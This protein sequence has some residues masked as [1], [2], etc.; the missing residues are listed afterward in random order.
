M[1]LSTVKIILSYMMVI[2]VKSDLHN[3]YIFFNIDVGIL[4][5]GEITTSVSY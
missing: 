1:E 4:L 3:L 2:I 5:V